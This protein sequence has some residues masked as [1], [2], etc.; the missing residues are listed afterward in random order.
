MSLHFVHVFLLNK[1]KAKVT[2]NK[3][4]PETDHRT[5]VTP[6]HTLTSYHLIRSIS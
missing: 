6:N 4:N 3:Q 1:E 2:V 5:E